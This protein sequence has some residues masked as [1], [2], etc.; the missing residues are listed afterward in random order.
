MTTG[1]GRPS[2]FGL[3]P[4]GS[5]LERVEVLQHPGA[6]DA[7]GDLRTGMRQVRSRHV[8]EQALALWQLAPVA[9]GEA[10]RRDGRGN[11]STRCS[12]PTSTPR[13]WGLRA[14]AGGREAAAVGCYEV[15]RTKWLRRSALN[16]NEGFV[17]FSKDARQEGEFG[18]R[19]RMT[20]GAEGSILLSTSEYSVK[21]P[22]LNFC[23][24]GTCA[25]LERV[26]DRGVAQ[27]VDLKCGAGRT[28]H[29][30]GSSALGRGLKG[31][32]R[33]SGS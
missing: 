11:A 25:E 13:A 10:V 23:W 32:G 9:L 33:R 12:N 15:G 26:A 14:Q 22:R 3:R 18:P 28:G 5:G 31:G 19:L 4:A 8:L 30:A 7:V 1:L 6:L 16:C 2:G 29:E 21:R 17:E 24:A 27:S 20:R